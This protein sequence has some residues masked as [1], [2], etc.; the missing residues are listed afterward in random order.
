M[1][2]VGLYLISAMLTCL[3]ATSSCS[4]NRNTGHF[5]ADHLFVGSTPC[6]PFINSFLKISSGTKCDFIKW[7]L[8]FQKNKSDSFHLIVVYGESKPNTNG[9]MGGGAK[10][11]I[12]GKY[13]TGDAGKA[14]PYTKVYYLHSATF[15]SP[16]LLIEMDENILHF[17]YANNTFIIGN[18]GYSFVL[19]R[20]Q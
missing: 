2:R 19:N 3:V 16:V 9:F 11:V 5:P 6:D 20:M 13:K 1:K 7:E 17:A 4:Q 10:L 8:R 12:D 15:R 14:N 18:A